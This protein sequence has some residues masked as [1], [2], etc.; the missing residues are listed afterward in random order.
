MS[1]VSK[2]VS[3]LKFALSH[4]A[5]VRKE[6]LAVAT[7]VASDITFFTQFVHVSGTTATWV[8]AVQA[9]ATFIITFL[10]QNQPKGVALAADA[11]KAGKPLKSVK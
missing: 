7:S 4:P 1:F 10:G 6:L 5:T 3:D 2:L 8:S 9:V 11:A